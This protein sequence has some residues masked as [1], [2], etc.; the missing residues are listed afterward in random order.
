MIDIVVLYFFIYFIKKND[1]SQKKG[2]FAGQ[3]YQTACFLH[4]L[5]LSNNLKI[6][7][8]LSLVHLQGMTNNKIVYFTQVHKEC[9][10][11][12]YIS[13]AKVLTSILYKM[14]F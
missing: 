8:K 6:T 12:R 7:T 10:K 4:L 1:F 5:Q 11:Y 13:N 9:N 14:C 2:V 3:F